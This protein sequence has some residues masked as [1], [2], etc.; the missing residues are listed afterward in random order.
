M[1]THH[2]IVFLLFLHGFFSHSNA[3]AQ[4]I[5]GDTIYVEANKVVRVV[6]PSPPGKAELL[7]NDSLERLY[8]VNDMGGNALSILALK[9][10]AKNQYLEV[11]EGDRKHLFI[12]SYK[13]GNPARS[14]DLSTKGKIKA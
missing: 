5:R 9:K 12:I 8:E 11:T 1:K 10:E 2:C 4:N 6:F 13:E 7:D 3:E 14:I